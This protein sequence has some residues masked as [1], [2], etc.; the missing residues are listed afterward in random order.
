MKLSRKD[1]LKRTHLL[2]DV[3][4]WDEPLL[5]HLVMLMSSCM[6]IDDFQ[7]CVRDV[8]TDYHIRTGKTVAEDYYGA[9]E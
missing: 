9:V 2:I 4:E 5:W 7:A 6:E 1:A 8:E 3:E